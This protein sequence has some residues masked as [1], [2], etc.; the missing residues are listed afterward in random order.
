VSTGSVGVG[1]AENSSGAGC[2]DESS[3]AVAMVAVSV[4][5]VSVGAGCPDESSGAREPGATL[6]SCGGLAGLFPKRTS[7]SPL[8]PN[9]AAKR[10]TPSARLSAIQNMASGFLSTEAH[11]SR[12][13]VG[14]VD[15]RM[16]VLDQR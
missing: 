13:G 1:C 5:T 14:R 15:E 3:G 6:A 8:G 4:G 16:E 9:A 2:P 10:T 7:S 11:G 12:E